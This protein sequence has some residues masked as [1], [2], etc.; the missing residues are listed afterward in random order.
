MTIG[1][2][3]HA[4]LGSVAAAERSPNDVMVMPSRQFGDLLVAD[5]TEPVLRFPQME[6]P[7][8]SSQVLCHLHAQAF[9]EVEFPSWVLRVG[10]ALDFTVP[11]DGYP[12]G[13]E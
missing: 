12:G 11:P 7:P 8:S 13:L 1:M 10:C 6:Q 5:R 4:V 9:L 3:Q 2:Q